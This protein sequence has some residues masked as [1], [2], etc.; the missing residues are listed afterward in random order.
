MWRDVRLMVGRT[1]TNDAAAMHATFQQAQPMVS[2]IPRY[3]SNGPRAH[4]EQTTRICSTHRSS[5]L[6]VLGRRGN[7]RT[8]MLPITIETA[9]W[10]KETDLETK[11]LPKIGE[12][13]ST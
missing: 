5:W 13:Y 10:G 6:G 2:Q 1:R 3:G 11:P 8:G 4:D 9:K 12:M 7:Q